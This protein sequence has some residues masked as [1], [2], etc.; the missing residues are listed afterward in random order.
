MLVQRVLLFVE[1]F[2]EPRRSQ[3]LVARPAAALPQKVRL[4]KA[5]MVM[6][7]RELV[8]LK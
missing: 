6:V 5:R 3:R 2:L 7:M 1:R 8:L 4:R